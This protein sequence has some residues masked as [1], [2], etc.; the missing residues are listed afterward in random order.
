M[1]IH[2][3]KILVR[4]FY[5]APVVFSTLKKSA[6]T[7]SH[8]LLSTLALTHLSNLPE[9]T[10][11]GQY[12]MLGRPN[13]GTKLLMRSHKCQTEVTSRIDKCTYHTVFS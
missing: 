5:T 6:L 2:F 1:L 7:G 11:L 9:P 12:L 3:F 10:P 8:H 4:L 13:V